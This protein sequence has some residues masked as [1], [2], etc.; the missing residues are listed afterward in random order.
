MRHRLTILAFL[1]TVFITLAA[2]PVKKTDPVQTRKVVSHSL[3][4]LLPKATTDPKEAQAY[5][6]DI[7]GKLEK[8]FAKTEEISPTTFNIGLMLRSR[9][10]RDVI[11]HFA[12]DEKL[13]DD[14]VIAK[15]SSYPFTTTTLW[16]KSTTKTEVFEI[17]TP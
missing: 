4:V 1:S 8:H 5:A 2:A 12:I 9:R 13:A 3:Q 7:F 11:I 17:K 16:S 15:L 6:K 10:W 14:A